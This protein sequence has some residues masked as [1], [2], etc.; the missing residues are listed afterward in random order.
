MS[1]RTIVRCSVG[2]GYFPF[3]LG[4]FFAAGFLAAVFFAAGLEAPFFAGVFFAAALASVFAAR[5]ATFFAPFA[6]SASGRAFFTTGAAFSFASGSSV[7]PIAPAS[8]STTSDQR[9]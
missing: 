2:I 6:T 1:G 4:V 3:F 8:T 7:A 9:M 5:L